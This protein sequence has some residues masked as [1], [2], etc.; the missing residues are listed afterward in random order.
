MTRSMNAVRCA[1][2]VL[3]ALLAGCAAGPDFHRPAAPEVKGYQSEPLPAPDADAQRLVAAMDIPAQWWT[4]F[5]SQPLNAL[6]DAALAANPDVAAAQ[7]ALHAARENAYAQQGAFFPGVEASINPT[8]QKTAGALSAVPSSGAYI[9]NLHTAQ[10]GISYVP[11]VFGGNRRQVESLQAQAEVQKFQLEATYLT[12]AS[13]VVNAAVQEAASRAQIEA[14][15]AMIRN[16]SKTLDSYRRQ[17]ALGQLAEADVAMQEAALAQMQA[18]LPPLHKQLALARD[19]LKAL[20]GAYPDQDRLANFSFDDINLPDELPLSLPARLV[21][22]RPDVRAAQAQMH[23]ASAQI[24][25]AIANRLPNISID[26]SFGSAA[27][28]FSQLFDAGSGFWNL[29]AN[30][31]QP[32]FQGGTLLHRQRAAEAVYEQAAAQYRSTVIV[33]FQNVADTLPAVQADTDAW[34]A[35]AAAERAA[36]RSRDIARRLAQLG[37]ISTLEQL[38]VETNWYQAEINLIQARANRLAD[39]VALLQALGGGWWNRADVAVSDRDAAQPDAAA[40]SR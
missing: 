8:R 22:Q 3:P 24:G 12:L 27:P 13:N 37:S 20:S 11:D 32:I 9:Y 16:Q 34:K 10:L 38:G 36:L 14:T 2:L 26:G 25:V 30:I 21:E 18:A 15:E 28:K 39:S 6:V 29:A 19:L 31:T 7:A 17:F 4:L 40:A 1:M 23:S 5:H 35:A 33:A